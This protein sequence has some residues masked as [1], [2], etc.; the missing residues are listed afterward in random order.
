MKLLFLP[1]CP[2]IGKL[3]AWMKNNYAIEESNRLTTDS[4]YDNNNTPLPGKLVEQPYFSDKSPYQMMHWQKEH[5]HRSFGNGVTNHDTYC[6]VVLPDGY[7]LTPA[8]IQA[9]E[10]YTVSPT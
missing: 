9:I 2:D 5:P 7:V 1:P 6:F 3:H 4:I 8:Q 10:T